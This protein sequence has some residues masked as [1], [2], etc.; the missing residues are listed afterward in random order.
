M[1]NLKYY[2][3]LS[4]K[5]PKEASVKIGFWVRLNPGHPEYEAGALRVL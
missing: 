4:T 3:R 2:R 1:S 5:K